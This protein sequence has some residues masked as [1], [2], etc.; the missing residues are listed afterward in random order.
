MNA[1]IRA[2]WSS[3]VSFFDA[4]YIM[5]GEKRDFCHT[6]CKTKRV[7]PGVGQWAVF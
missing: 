4:G 7:D 2:E 1:I 3:S 5:A 6:Y